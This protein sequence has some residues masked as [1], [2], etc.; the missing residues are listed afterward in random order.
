MNLKKKKKKE[1]FKNK[2]CLRHFGEE[3]KKVGTKRNK[4]NLFQWKKCLLKRDKKSSGDLMQVFAANGIFNEFPTVLKIFFYVIFLTRTNCSLFL[5]RVEIFY[6]CH[7]KEKP[8][9]ADFQS[10]QWQ[11]NDFHENNVAH[12][13]CFITHPLTK[14]ILESYV[15]IGNKF[16]CIRY[17]FEGNPLKNQNRPICF[18]S[19]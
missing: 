14:G 5:I 3:K 11:C 10:F 17:L 4:E 18:Y 12:N 16:I 13:L 1:I 8:F 2:I 9:Y 6:V 19:T 7:W 15:L